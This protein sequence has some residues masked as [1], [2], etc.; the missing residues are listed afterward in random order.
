MLSFMSDLRVKIFGVTG[1]APSTLATIIYFQSTAKTAWKMLFMIYKVSTCLLYIFIIWPSICV[2]SWK[3]HFY[4]VTTG[5]MR[6]YF[7]LLS[8]SGVLCQPIFLSPT[9]PPASPHFISCYEATAES[10]SFHT[11]ELAKFSNGG[12]LVTSML[13][14]HFAAHVR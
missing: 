14:G 12:G 8:I 6:A 13:Q 7:N 10:N 2:V 11:Q 1:G 3:W 9:P 5:C 4:C